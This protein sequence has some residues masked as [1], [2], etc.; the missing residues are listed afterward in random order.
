VELVLD[1]VCEPHF[2]VAFLSPCKLRVVGAWRELPR[3]GSVDLARAV[4]WQPDTC[5]HFA[6]LLLLVRAK[7]PAPSVQLLGFCVQRLPSAPVAAVTHSPC[8]SPLAGDSLYLCVT[9]PSCNV[10]LDE[11]PVPACGTE[12]IATALMRFTLFHDRGELP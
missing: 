5:E 12:A 8:R 10:K 9:V 3:P 7:L 6:V 11:P 1:A 4:A 2:N